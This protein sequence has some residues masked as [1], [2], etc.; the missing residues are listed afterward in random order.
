MVIPIIS[1]LFSALASTAN[2]Q[3]NRTMEHNMKAKKTLVAFFSRAGENYAVGNI[4]EGNTRIIADMIVDETGGDIFQITP[5]T[6][7]PE[8]YAQCTEVAKRELAAKAR[9]AVKGD[10][11][12]E[13]YDTIFIGYPNWWGD[14][15]MP[16]YT[17]IEKYRWQGKT[18]IPFCTHE[19]S[20]LSGTE[21]KLETACQGATL[22]KG[23]ALRGAT[24]QNERARA[25]ESINEWLSKL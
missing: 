1:L 16:V 2:K 7:Y 3:T 9:P 25:K 19:G 4:A 20:G 15:P 14:M 18:V 13:D 23:I 21:H 17:F 6:P 8:D 22:L 24:A 11:A 10:A 12:V 5:E